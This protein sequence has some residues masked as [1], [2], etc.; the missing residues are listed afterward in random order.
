MPLLSFLAVFRL[1]QLNT[2]MLRGFVVDVP[3]SVQQHKQNVGTSSLKRYYFSAAT[4][5]LHDG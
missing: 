2:I 4:Q 5:M 1:F 3:R